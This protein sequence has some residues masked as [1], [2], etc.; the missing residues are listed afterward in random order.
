VIEESEK[1]LEKKLCADVKSIKGWAIKLLPGL[2]TGLP[3]RICLFK[4]GILVFVELKTT[5]KKP[6]PI[7]NVIHKKLRALGFRVEVIDRSVQI[8]QLIKSVKC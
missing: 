4:G 8:D 6:T 7:Q 1:V 5:G 3:D 2:I